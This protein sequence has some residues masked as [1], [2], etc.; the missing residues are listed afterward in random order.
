MGSVELVALADGVEGEVLVVD[1]LTPS[2]NGFCEPPA[3]QAN[4]SADRLRTTE[5]DEAERR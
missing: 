5:R 3:L 2:A 4:A 1:G